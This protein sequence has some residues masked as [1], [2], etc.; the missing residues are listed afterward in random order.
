LWWPVKF[1]FV[2]LI[3]L[4]TILI[5]IKS[6]DYYTPDFSSGYL[7]DK[8]AAFQGIF[9]IGLYAHIAST[10]LLLLLGAALL[11]FKL[12]FYYPTWHRMAG[13]LYAILV[14]VLAAPGGC[15]LSFYSYGGISSGIA[16]FLA[17][18]VWVLITVNAVQWARRK[19][20]V[21]HRK[22]MLR[23]FALATS[24]IGLRIILFIFHEYI[25]WQGTQAY[26][27]GVWLSFLLPMGLMEFYLKKFPRRKYS[28]S[29]SIYKA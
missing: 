2:S 5:G 13:W 11:V 26:I 16:F 6:V 29:T 12:E 22:W 8:K 25:P 4:V 20:F 10:P 1:F 19:N 24:A 28:S 18:M 14:V 3:L 7:S 9:A 23:S 17:S 27:C 21:E 15:I